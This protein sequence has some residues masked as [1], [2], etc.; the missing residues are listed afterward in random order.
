MAPPS[1]WPVPKGLAT[2][3]E[4]LARPR[5]RPP[6]GLGRLGQWARTR[7]R[8]KRASKLI[9]KWPNTAVINFIWFSLCSKQKLCSQ[10]NWFLSCG[11]SWPA[12]SFGQQTHTYIHTLT[13]THTCVFICHLSVC[14]CKFLIRQLSAKKS[15]PYAK[16]LISCVSCEFSYSNLRF[17]QANLELG[18]SFDVWPCN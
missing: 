3:D 10:A 7:A 6:S 16:Q 4:D 15:F 5:S 2:K 11:W 14:V 8:R 1:S 12:T 17:C 13:R 9:Y 18:R